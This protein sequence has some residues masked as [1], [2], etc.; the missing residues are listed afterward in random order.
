LSATEQGVDAI[1]GRW[2]TIPR[3]LCFVLNGNDVL[4]MKRASHRRVFPNRYNGV[5]GHIERYE[6]PLASIIREITEETD[7]SVDNVRL[8]SVHNIDANGENGIMMFVFT[9]I[10]ASRKFKDSGEEGT[11]HWIPRNQLLELD[12]VDDL[13]ELLPRI[14]RMDDNDPP[15]FVHV[16]YDECDNIRLRFNSEMSGK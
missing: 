2:L 12:L 7:L 6:D 11:L 3:A 13:P 8:R 4:L 16:S 15:F 10:S 9:A 14:L 5:G 1:H